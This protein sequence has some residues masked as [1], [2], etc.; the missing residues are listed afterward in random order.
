MKETS[1]LNVRMDKQL[2]SQ[3]EEILSE[4]G[5]NVSTAV[6]MFARQ[7]VRQGRIPFEI[8]LDIPNKETAKAIWEAESL[9]RESKGKGYHDVKS[10]FDVL[11]HD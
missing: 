4:L 7:V 8:S 11:L 1:N 10:L 6:N 3:M 5:L 2:K 9:A